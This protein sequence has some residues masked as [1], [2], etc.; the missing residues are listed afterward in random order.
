MKT[1]VCL[2]LVLFCSASFVHA[3]NGIRVMIRDITSVE[4]VGADN[5]LIGYGLVVGLN[6]TGDRRQTLFTTQTLASVLQ[7][8]GVQ[9]PAAAI[10][11]NNV[12]A[13]FVTAT[14]P[15]FARSGTQLDVT[16]YSVG[17]A[18]LS[19]AGFCFLRHYAVRTAK[20]TQLPRGRWH[21]RDSPAGTSGN[22][23]QLNHP[24]VARIPPGGLVERDAPTNLSA[25]PHLTLLLA[26][27][28]FG[29]HEAVATA[30]NTELG[31][32]V[33]NVADGR[34]IELAIDRLPAHNIPALLARIE[35]LPVTIQPKPRVVVNERTG[36]VVI[37]KDVKLGAASILHG[38]LTIDIS[39]EFGA[40]QPGPFSN[41]TTTPIAQPTVR[42][43]ESQA[44][45]IEL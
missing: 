29:A 12:A 23:K 31:A 1:R 15:P 32:P 3:S 17:D 14:L 28:D 8:M 13:V 37:G 21:L 10:R 11:V 33:A 41:G 43:V 40:S 24:T 20:C 9:V 22:S 44:R 34:R 35:T 39:T 30:I 25:L 19:K 4:G 2:V 6:G 7:R 27:Q 5:A 42:D 38:S 26:D 36:T 45:K 18:K 16:V